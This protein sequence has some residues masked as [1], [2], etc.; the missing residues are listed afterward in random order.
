[1]KKTQLKEFG[2]VKM[3]GFF[4]RDYSDKGIEKW[5]KKRYKN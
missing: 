5:E 3:R 2:E 4:K 1:M